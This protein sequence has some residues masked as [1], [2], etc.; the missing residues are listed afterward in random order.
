MHSYRADE[1]LMMIRAGDEI[2]FKVSTF[3]HVLEGYKVADEIAKHGAGAS[4]FSDWWAYKFEVYDAI[5]YNGALMRERG[6][7]VSFNSDSDEL[8][9]RLNGEAAKAVKYG[10]VP[11]VDALAFVTMNPAKQLGVDK[12]VG[13]LEAGKDGDFVIWNGD[14]L[15]AES[16]AQETWIEGRKY[17]DRVARPA[18]EKE[19]ADLVAK[20]KAQLPAAPGDK[21]KIRVEVAPTPIPHL[22]PPGPTPTPVPRAR[23]RA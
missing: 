19:R 13:S 3:Q 2:G 18:L 10:G 15:S 22:A 14:P 17:F 23:S 9:R 11:P 7:V 12:R 8:A 5:P 6:V 16:V 21:G 4:T 20:A 1:I